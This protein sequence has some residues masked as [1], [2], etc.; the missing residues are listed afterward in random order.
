VDQ[1]LFK[2]HAKTVESLSN[3]D[4]D[5][6]LTLLPRSVHQVA[7]V[8]HN[9]EAVKASIQI[10]LIDWMREPP[11]ESGDLEKFQSEVTID[12]QSPDDIS[13]ATETGG[14]SKKRNAESMTVLGAGQA[15]SE[16]TAVTEL[17]VRKN[18]KEDNK[19]KEDN[20]ERKE[21]APPKIL[22]LEN[23]LNIPPPRT[24]RIRLVKHLL[25]QQYPKDIAHPRDIASVVFM[26]FTD[27]EGHIKGRSTSGVVPTRRSSS[28]TTCNDEDVA[29]GEE[30][31]MQLSCTFA[32]STRL[33]ST[34]DA[35]AGSDSSA[36]RGESTATTISSTDKKNRKVKIDANNM[37]NLD[38]DNDDNN[39][40]NK[41]CSSESYHGDHSIH[42][43]R[44]EES[45]RWSCIQM[46]GLTD[47]RN[48]S[49]Q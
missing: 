17:K 39:D 31:D 5:H 16:S 43:V 30:E 22:R 26:P 4:S 6:P 21:P 45:R 8:V 48:N 40:D 47:Q 38:D 49:T 46:P 34:S 29:H 14:S 10:H 1:E 12:W 3:I 23:Y 20:A 9:P 27:R 42:C 15:G 37:D 44:Q 24:T 18:P 13:D 25:A 33:S 2:C 36:H 28:S 11:T 7:A 19:D 35:M 32:S 41:S